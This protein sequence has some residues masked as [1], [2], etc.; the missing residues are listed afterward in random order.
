LGF[1]DK[2]TADEELVHLEDICRSV[3]A[4]RLVEKRRGRN[5]SAWRLTL[6]SGA[7]DHGTANW[8]L[9]PWT[10]TVTEQFEPYSITA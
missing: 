10:R 3:I 7:V 1:T 9:L 4:G 5:G 6:A 8:P 2:V